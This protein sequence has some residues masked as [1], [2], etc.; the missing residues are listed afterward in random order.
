MKGPLQEAEALSAGRVARIVLVGGVMPSI[1][2]RW[3]WLISCAVF[4]TIL[5][6][7]VIAVLLQDPL[8]G[9]LP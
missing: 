9:S 7:L 3:E 1:D 8:S 5:I 6:A 4:G 2:R